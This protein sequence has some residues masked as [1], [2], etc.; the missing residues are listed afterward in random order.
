[1]TEMEPPLTTSIGTTPVLADGP[2]DGF[3][4]TPHPD[5]EPEGKGPKAA[6]LP[7][8]KHSSRRKGD[9]Q[10]QDAGSRISSKMPHLTDIASRSDIED[11]LMDEND[12]SITSLVREGTQGDIRHNPKRNKK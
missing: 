10:T 3:N 2:T 5:D 1:M 6:D 4:G 9:V 11:T 12:T 7:Q 8:N